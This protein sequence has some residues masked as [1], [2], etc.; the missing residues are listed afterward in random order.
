MT[1]MDGFCSAFISVKFNTLEFK[2]YSN[3]CSSLS[4]FIQY[5]NYHFNTCL[6]INIGRYDCCLCYRSDMFSVQRIPPQKGTTRYT[7]CTCVANN[8]ALNFSYRNKMFCMYVSVCQ[9]LSV[10]TCV[11]V[12]ASKQ[13]L[14]F[15][16]LFHICKLL[17]ILKNNLTARR[18][19]PLAN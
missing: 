11:C 6:G 10:C 15:L 9:C 8:Y 12:C 17:P 3:L 19:G 16:L 7:P 5:I 13:K 14:Q 4:A 18:Y 2:V 1:C